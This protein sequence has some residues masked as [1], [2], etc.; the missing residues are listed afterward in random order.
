MSRLLR[1]STLKQKLIGITMLAC[2]CALLGA[3]AAFIIYDFIT[4]RKELAD[5]LL[6][7]VKVQEIHNT[8]PLAFKDH[9]TA[10]ENLATLNADSHILSAAIYDTDGLVFAGYRRS[11]DVPLPPNLQGQPEVLFTNRHL[12]VSRTIT[13]EHDTIGHIVVRIDLTAQQERFQWLLLISAVVLAVSLAVAYLIASRL[14][15]AITGPITA[16]THAAHRVSQQKDYDVHVAKQDDDE[17]GLLSDGFN[18]MLAQIRERDRQLIQTVEQL[19]HEI[20]ERTEAEQTLEVTAR[21]LEALLRTSPLAIISLDRTGEHI[22][23]WGGAAE[24]IFGW[25]KEEVLGKPLPIIPDSDRAR[26]LDIWDAVNRKESVLG[27]EV[28]RQRKDGSLVDVMLWVTALRD[29]D[30]QPMES[31]AF[32][33]DISERK[34]AEAVLRSSLEQIRQMQKMEALGQ[35][36]GGIAHDFNNLLTGILGNAELAATKLTGED[37]AQANLLRIQE[38]GRRASSVVQQILAFTRQQDISRTVQSIAPIVDEAFTL[39]RSTLP[40]GIQLIHTVDPATP[41]ALINAT[42]IHQVL[43]N[44]CTNSWHALGDKPGNISIEL[45][46]VTLTQPL[47]SLQTTLPTGYYAR[48][49][50]QDT[51]C[52]MTPDTVAR[53]FDPFF[54]TKQQGQGTGLGLSVVHGIIQQHDG[55]ITVESSPGMGTTFS[56]YFPA[57]QSETPLSAEKDPAAS[58]PRAEFQSPCHLLYVD[59]EDM[60]VELVKATFQPMGYRVT[61]TTNPQEALNT[62][63][64]DPDRFDVVVTDYNMPEM[65][66]LEM[67]R[68]LSAI[69]RTLPVVLVS[70]YLTP[71]SHAAALAAHVQDIVYKPTM[72]KELVQVLNRVLSPP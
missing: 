24:Q 70:G 46:P 16:L 41:S 59:D 68:R 50:V 40:A 60:L 4:Y 36:A 47:P 37:P 49:S 66:G 63:R 14:H 22:V 19:R 67:A 61:G 7:R 11:P 8:A 15:K 29:N 33:A 3:A 65:S 26:A 57:S 56:L 62:V 35:L 12:D 54:T 45:G 71:E 42:Q 13:L 1:H 28:R 69:R 38:A 18:T 27:I 5:N 58:P 55:A 64:A 9:E 39:L 43:M 6:T 25:S 72:L 17:I 53:I 48:L 31:V 32:L 34:R 44:L 51:G 30:S 10:Q 20:M 2:G 23:T 52:G 21:K